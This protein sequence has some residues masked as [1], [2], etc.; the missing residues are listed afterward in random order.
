MIMEIIKQ[1]RVVLMIVVTVLILV[2]IRAL[3]V[4]HFKSDAKRLAEPSLMRSN[5]LNNSQL[6]A[7][8]GNKLLIDLSEG[9][10]SDTYNITDSEVINILPD[11][12]LNKDNLNRLH[13]FNGNILLISPDRALA[14]RIWMVLSQMGMNNVYILSDD[15]D[16]ESFKNKFR[17]DTIT[18]PEL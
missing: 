10:S 2:I 1:Y 13:K 12:I 16:N 5:I 4:N 18:G 3:G 17:P 15:S 6:A 9:P 7:L 11:A 14:A 8:K